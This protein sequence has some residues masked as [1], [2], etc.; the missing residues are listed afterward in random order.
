MVHPVL[1]FLP[2]ERARLHS[3]L[4]SVSLTARRAFFSALYTFAHPG[5][6]DPLPNLSNERS[7][8]EPANLVVALQYQNSAAQTAAEKLVGLQTVILMILATELTGPTNIEYRGWYTQAFGAAAFHF[9][10][11]RRVRGAGKL[12]GSDADEHHLLARRAWLAFVTLEHWHAAGTA[13][14]TMCPDELTQLVADDRLMLG[15]VG[16]FLLRK[17]S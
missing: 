1:P 8:M 15:D 12:L 5:E 2:H 14:P 7:Y 16:Y 11:L 13:S 4:M 6:Y 3:N 10:Y 9:G 17:Y